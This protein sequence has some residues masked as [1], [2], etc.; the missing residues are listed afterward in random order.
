[1]GRRAD[2]P[3]EG[4]LPRLSWRLGVEVELLAPPGAD[5]RQLAERLA[6][7]LGGEVHA[8]FH[9]QSEP[10]RVPGKAAFRNLTPGFE[11]RGPDGAWLARCVDDLTLQ[12]DLDREAPPAGGWYRVVSDDARLLRLAARHCDPEGALPE[13]VA[14]L[15]AL[16]G[17]EP[18]P[19]EGGMF[20]VADEGGQPICIAARLPGERERPCELISPP[21]DAD[22]LARLAALLEPARALGFTAPAEGATHLHFDARPLQ[23]AAVLADLVAWWQAW[24]P[25][26]GWLWG[27]NPRC[28]R[29]GPTPPKEL[30]LLRDPAFRELPW[31]E[32]RRRLSALEPSKYVDLNLRNLAKASTGKNTL[33]VRTLPVLQ[34]A[35]E[36]VLCAA[37]VEGA[38]R[39]AQLGIPPG[40]RSP[41]PPG[42]S[43]AQRMLA[44]LPLSEE[45]EQAWRARLAARA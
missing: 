17:T 33:E 30:A 21:I 24:G 7:E 36:I 12:A 31:P 35:E 22:H 3:G 15:A 29:L 34:D 42:V 10:S 26:L 41:T 5:R 1:M 14:P 2:R 18:E 37:L 44:E 25:T 28:V 20:R 43:G 40:W 27:R 11:V 8:F 45:V 38:L 6:A 39:R 19:G 16:F 32:A 4:D 13:A 9:P 23:R